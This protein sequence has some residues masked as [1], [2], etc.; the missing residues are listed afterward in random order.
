M[1][2]ATREEWLEMAATHLGAKVF[3]PHG[4]DLPAIK[5]TVGFPSTNALGMRQRR[6]GE[7]WK[8]SCSTDNANQIFLSPLL[9]NPIKYV[10][11]L[12]HELVHAVDDCENG[13]KGKFKAI[14]Q[15]IGLTEGP[16]KSASA[17]SELLGVIQNIIDELGEFPHGTLSAASKEKK[18]STRL[19]KVVCP[20]CGYT[21]RTTAKWIEVG[22][23]ICPCGEEMQPENNEEKE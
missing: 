12:A 20:G 13:H 1:K 5:V 22:M 3:S 19:L 6:I 18:Q 21:V 2:H 23:P 7:C 11:V 17:G 9:D 14:C 8:R 10:D 16:P 4:Y 15:K